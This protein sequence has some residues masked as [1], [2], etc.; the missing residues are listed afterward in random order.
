MG[1]IAAAVK[2]MMD[3]GL[4]ADQI[5]SAIEDMEAA[6]THQRTARQE[7][8][9]RY[10]DN[11]KRL[12]ASENRLNK[13]EASESDGAEK[14]KKEKSPP[15]PP[16]KEKTK[17][18]PPKSPD[19]GSVAATD[20]ACDRFEEF[21]QAYPSRPNNP[22]KPARQKF[23]RAVKAGADP[24]VIIR[25]AG[26]LAGQRKG[27][28]P[29]FTPMASTWLNQER[30]NDIAQASKPTQ[31]VP[32]VY[33]YGQNYRVSEVHDMLVRYFEGNGRWEWHSQLGYQPGHHDC[34][35]PEHM[36]ERARR[37]AKPVSTQ[38]MRAMS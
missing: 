22:K 9:R 3:A 30:W 14:N 13:T 26:I 27:Q 33:I 10:Y 23:D 16:L 4:D 34:E 5:V 19:G 28:D 21:W 7:R 15:A 24:S 36:I 1:A 2:H 37:E 35:I 31:E 17:K 20:V 18:S 32:R 11:C 29:Q 25:A 12:K 38:T 6:T 8:N